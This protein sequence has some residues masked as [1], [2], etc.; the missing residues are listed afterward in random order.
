MSEIGE[1]YR[2]IKDEVRVRK[3]VTYEENLEVLFL[4]EFNF[5]RAFEIKEESK[6]VLF[7]EKKM[8]P[9]V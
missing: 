5:P 1:M 9:C 3:A 4:S 6:T 2:D 7:R 8:P